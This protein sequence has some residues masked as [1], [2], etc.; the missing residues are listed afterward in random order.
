M[1]LRGVTGKALILLQVDQQ[2]DRP[3]DFNSMAH[4]CQLRIMR[5]VACE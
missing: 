3:N 1:I 4:V 5:H 2:L